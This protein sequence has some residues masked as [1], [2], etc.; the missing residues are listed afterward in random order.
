MCIAEGEACDAESD[1]CCEGS[2][3]VNAGVG[4]APTCEPCLTAGE[5]CFNGGN[6]P[7]CSPLTC[8]QGNDG[9]LACG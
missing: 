6:T 5:A 2:Q 7:C 4:Q 1:Q 8:M 9:S 3:C